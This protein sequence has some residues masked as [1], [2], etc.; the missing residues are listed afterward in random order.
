MKTSGSLLARAAVVAVIALVASQIATA[1][2]A[3]H[4]HSTHSHSQGSLQG[5]TMRGLTRAA[6]GTECAGVGY[7]VDVAGPG[8][9]CTHGPDPAPEGV[10]LADH[11]STTEVRQAAEN[12]SSSA[13][14]CD[15][16]GV[17]GNRVETIYA[18]ASDT[19][20]RYASVVAALRGYAVT[21]IE[22][23]V[24]NSSGNLRRPRFVTTPGPACELIVRNVV[25]NTSGDGSFANTLSQLQAKGY[26]RVDR[27]Y[28]VWMD[29]K[30]GD[31]APYCGIGLLANDSSPGRGNFHNGHP[32]GGG[33]VSR[34]DL[35][36]WGLTGASDTPVEAHELFHTLGAVQ[37]N[38][39][40]STF[41]GT[42]GSGGHC[43]DDYDVMCYDDD[44]NPSTVPMT[45]PCATTT[46]ERLLDCGGDDYFSLSPAP[47]TYLTNHWNTATSSFLV[48]APDMCTVEGNNSNNVLRG[49]AGVDV[50]CGMGGNDTIKAKAKDIVFGGAGNDTL[51]M[52]LLTV[53][54]GALMKFGIAGPL[55]AAG[56]QI[57]NPISFHTDV[58][59]VRGASKNDSL[60]GNAKANKIYGGGGNDSLFGQAGNDKLYGEG[61]NDYMD[62]G[63][64]NDSC[65][66]GPG[67]F[68]KISC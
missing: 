39:P 66:S 28:M 10:D 58:E 45:F 18:R 5:M 64:G 11:K 13:V 60:S 29:I 52:S 4:D 43:H 36:C 47:A 50:F 1:Q 38:A 41:L 63:A 31:T 3:S 7:E 55:N 26:N 14:D 34:V 2:A 68:R 23:I 56:N 30:V 22:D 25:L 48:G 61:G 62:G 16:D 51:D 46:S 67:F 12:A 53:K 59:N 42:A 37:N 21:N 20:D 54:L 17:S 57:V 49:T 24:Q 35:P 15:G 9:Y 32:F 44:F 19:T 65:I 8:H 40:H 27:K 33:A 6:P